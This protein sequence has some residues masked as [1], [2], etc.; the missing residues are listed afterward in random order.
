M[1]GAI[2]GLFS[3]LKCSI[4]PSGMGNSKIQDERVASKAF[5]VGT[6]LNQDSKDATST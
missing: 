6:S 2:K 3:T 1:A 5:P 4:S